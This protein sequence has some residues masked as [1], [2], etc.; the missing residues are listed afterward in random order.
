MAGSAVLDGL[1]DVA[2]ADQDFK[3]ADWELLTLYVV[4]T[5]TDHVRLIVAE[6]LAGHIPWVIRLRGLMPLWFHHMKTFDVTDGD[7]V[8]LVKQVCEAPDMH[9]AS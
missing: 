1:I 6:H 9:P 2:A 3:G 8:I 5:K 7:S 4:P